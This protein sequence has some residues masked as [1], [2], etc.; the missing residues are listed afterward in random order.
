MHGFG[1]LVRWLAAKLSLSIRGKMMAT[2]F[3]SVGAVLVLSVL[4]FQLGWAVSD[5]MSGSDR[6]RQI[7]DNLI[8]MRVAV[9]EID[10]VVNQAVGR[11]GDFYQ[12]NLQMLGIAHKDFEDGY[13]HAA[14]FVREDGEALG[15]RD[16]GQEFAEIIKRLDE[17]IKPALKNDDFMSL[18]VAMGV[19]EAK[20]Q[21]L[22]EMLESSAER[23]GSEMSGHFKST[24]N[25]IQ[26]A[27]FINLA[28]SGGSLAILISLLVVS[29]ASI[30]RPLRG[31]TRSMQIL[32]QGNTEIAI[33]ARQRR[34]EIGAMASTVEVFRA[35]T[36]KMHGL[37]REREETQRRAAHERKQMMTDLA[38]RFD[39]GMRGLIEA[40]TSESGRLRDLAAAMAAVAD[41][42]QQ[43]G[44]E[45]SDASQLS[46]GNV[47]AVAA[48]SE[49]LSS[50]LKE[51]AQQIERSAGIAKKAVGEVE[52]TS[53]DVESV[54]TSAARINDVVKLIG[55]IA[56]QTNL[57]ALNA[58]IEAA[59]AGDAGKG[60]AVVASEVKN[61][62]TQAAQATENIT[63]Q[64]GALHS[65]V[66]RSVRSMT[67]VRSVIAE[68][69]AIASSVAAA[70]AQ[71][72]AATHEIA[73][74]VAQAADGNE[75][76]FAT[77]QLLADSARE[78]Q[79]TADAVHAA[80][81]LLTEAS[82]RLDRDIHAFL[83]QI[84]AA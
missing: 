31:L 27:E 14:S 67:E 54:A 26:R 79:Q 68:A 1:R 16:A 65:V 71:Q 75:R 66:S 7:R 56:S 80:S 59:R 61:L 41:A 73:Q 17:E 2:G 44:A 55:E 47:K 19:F 46:T 18:P 82:A 69:D 35:N 76:V 72:S 12:S 37:E 78:G 11:R 21:K 53:R 33:P 4:H 81:Q 13:K 20:I 58:T 83:N 51:V 39:A 30:L 74:N 60:F 57:L 5:Q 32:A 48:S 24:T 6:F 29:T 62:A 49:E 36:E 84:R 34:D 28:T 42:T 22:D 25:E 10:S 23:A 43:K 15:G 8:K 40:I 50:S 45:A 3:V 52:A 38:A 77:I 9:L 63:Q 64:I 70:I